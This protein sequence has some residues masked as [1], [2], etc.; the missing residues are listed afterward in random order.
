MTRKQTERLTRMTCGLLASAGFGSALLTMSS[1]GTAGYDPS[2]T[3]RPPVTLSGSTGSRAYEPPSDADVPNTPSGTSGGRTCG[4]SQEGLRLTLL[5]PQQHVGQ[6]NTSHPT[7]TWFVPVNTPLEGEFQIYQMG[8]GEFQR[9]LDIPYGFT[10]SQGFMT[11]TLPR[12]ETGL[13]SDSHYVWQVLLRCGSRPGD[14]YKVRAEIEV[15]EESA[16]LPENPAVDSVGQAEQLGTVGL[17]YDAVAA[18][19]KTPVGLNAIAF[20]S[21]LLTDLAELEATSE[22]QSTESFEDHIPHSQALRRIAEAKDSPTAN[23]PPGQ[24]PTN[25]PD[26]SDTE[27]Y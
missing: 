4:V 19:S 26:A 2:P 9:I 21:T 5:A 3:A 1:S 20:R 12:D 15:I 8:E 24:T 27:D 22:N 6:T 10:S 16:R 18:V 7:F 23:H 14:I 17:W 11:F 13:E 25:R